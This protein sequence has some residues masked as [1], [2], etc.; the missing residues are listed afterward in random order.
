MNS[1]KKIAIAVAAALTM[2]TFVAVPTHAAFGGDTLTIDAVTDT[3]LAGETATA[4]VTQ[5]FIATAAGDSL[6]VTAIAGDAVTLSPLP[7]FAVVETSSAVVT[8][9][10]TSKVYA[11]SNAANVFVRAQYNLNLVVDANATA[12]V[13]KFYIYPGTGAGTGTVGAATLLWTVTVTAPDKKASATYSTSFLNTGE[14]VSATADAT[15]FAPKAVSTDAAAV[16]VVTQKT[17]ANLAGAESMTVILSGAGMLGHG[18]NHATMSATARALVVPAGSYVGVFADGTAGVGTITI[19]SAS[20]VTLGTEKVTFYG[21]IAA[22]VTTVD[23]AVL[24]IGANAN[25]VTAI[26]YDASGVVV[27][28]GSLYVYSDTVSV[29]SESATAVAITD[30]SA[31]FTLTGVKKGS[32]G[33]VVKSGTSATSISSTVKTVRVEGTPTSVKI[34]FDKKQYIP[35]EIAKITVSIADED[36]KAF[37]AKTFAN[38]FA[39]GGITSSYSFGSGSDNIAVT[40]IITDT[41][42]T[43]VFTVYMPLT[44]ATIKISATGGSSLATA[45]QVVVTDSATVF[46]ANAQATRA[47]VQASIDASKEALEA[48]LGATDAAQAASDAA[49]AATAAAEEA[50]IAATAAKTSAD[51]ATAAVEKLAIDVAT[52]MASLQKQLATLAKVVAKIAVKIK[53]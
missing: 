51:A 32:A 48:A 40:S 6:S 5:T 23:K 44:E 18:T 26:A 28:N 34:A 1:F 15:V 16:I 25:S 35:G 8:G 13:Y 9:T 43:K 12:G 46:D 31:K 14:T 3:V 17:A 41:A 30:G 21:D 33:I 2:G 49:N 39:A 10:G 36:G 19:L 24:P 37:S 38:L 53:A 20:G 11:G 22:I 50:T 7:V 29:V 52:L 4:V 42:T 47:S 27:G 45:G